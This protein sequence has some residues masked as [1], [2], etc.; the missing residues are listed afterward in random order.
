MKIVKNSFVLIFWFTVS[1]AFAQ[2]PNEMSAPTI[3]IVE[4]NFYAALKEKAIENYDKAVDYLQQNIA[5][6]PNNPV[7]H[8]QLG[9]NY[10]ALKNYTQAEKSFQKAIEL[11]PNQKWYW[12]DLYDVYHTTKDFKKAI[13]IVTKLIEFDK[14]YQDDLVSLYMHAKEF[15]KALFLIETMEKQSKLSIVMERYKLQLLTEKNYGN[16]L[17]SDYKEAVSNNPLDEK[18]YVSLIQSYISNNQ[19]DKAYDII[20]EMAKKV[21]NSDWV[22]VLQFRNS[23][24]NNQYPPAY[25]ALTNVVNSSAI[26]ELMKHRA[27]NEYLIY[28]NQSNNYYAD[29]ETIVGYFNEQKLINVPKE[30]GIFFLNK[31]KISLAQQ[32][33]KNGILNDKND[34]QAICLYIETYLNQNDLITVEDLTQNYLAYFPSEARLYYFLGIAQ[35]GLNSPKK[36]IK[37]LQ[38]A[39]DY[40][41]DDTQLEANIYIQLGESYNKI[42]NQELKEKYFIKAN[43]LLNK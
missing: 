4:E 18:S 13:P 32:Y 6:E 3:N 1:I 20:A 23:L 17:K 36:A 24:K 40:L 10:L 41:I 5:K 14:D 25:K 15:D 29:L 39:L 38:E 33:L 7:F 28:V 22:Q 30:V 2:T 27:F 12:A 31:Q 42:G 34:V 8:N 43:H 37:T 21:P 16:K 19:F 26:T 35:Q 9:K 11:N